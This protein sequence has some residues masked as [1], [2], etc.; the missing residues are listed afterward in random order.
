ME[1][2]YII[3]SG[4]LELYAA[5]LATPEECI[6]VQ[7]ALKKYPEVKQEFWQIEQTM[8]LYISDH[9]MQPATTVKDKTF[10]AIIR[11]V[12][13]AHQE[14]GK[15]IPLTAQPDRNND[16][17]TSK[18]AD[19]AMWKRVAAACIF[20]LA[21]SIVINILLYRS[22]SNTKSELEKTQQLLTDVKDKSKALEND[23]QVVQS[24][25][26][27]PVTLNGLEASPEAAAKIFW[28]KNSGE[29]Y[30]D[31]SNLPAAPDGKQYQL[32]AIV[33]GKPV[34]AG[35]ILI[36]KK[37]DKYRIQ[38]MKTF[39]R[40]D[41]FAVTLESEAGNTAPKGPMFVMGKM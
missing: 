20:L 32:W 36:S 34:D 27:M 41:A 29:V 33:D 7:E 16:N 4:L 24:K 38:K 28:M 19:F 22:S 35:M 39:G 6:Q 25:Y 40:A 10:S 8:E 23:M 2:Q 9:A 18:N 3:S 26:S 11:D 13:N 15:I 37:G 14:N 5:G 17:N 31:P 30:I 1:A 12:E 21:A